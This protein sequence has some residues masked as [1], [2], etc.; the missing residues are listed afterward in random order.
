MSLRNVKSIWSVK[1]LIRLAAVMSC[2]TIASPGAA[3]AG[4]LFNG[5]N[6]SI[7]SFNDGTEGRIIGSESAFEFYGMAFREYEDKVVFAINS[8]LAPEGYA[9]NT[10]MGGAIGYGDLFINFGGDNFEAAEGTSDLYAVKFTDNDS[11]STFQNNR[12]QDRE[13]IQQGLYKNVSSRA[14]TT[15]NDGY[16]SIKSHTDAVRS[17]EG[18]AS[19]GDYGA[20]TEYFEASQ[21][22]RTHMDVEAMVNN[23]GR[24]RKNRHYASGITQLS[25]GDFDSDLDFGNFGAVGQYTFGFS[26]EKSALQVGNFVAHL[27]AECG[28]DGMVLEGEILGN[29]SSVKAVPESSA[30]A[31]VA[32]IGLLGGAMVLRKRKQQL[33]A[34]LAA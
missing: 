22:A 30:L 28:N 7:D 26:V 9:S 31:S 20:D 2:A 29:V 27:F 12:G 34:Q 6:Y 17:Y 1:S 5:W 8:N 4:Q 16:G 21:A 25:S 18:Q 24:L 23:G 15:V 19:F 13:A 3:Q 10:A 32:A 11:T 14:L 33:D